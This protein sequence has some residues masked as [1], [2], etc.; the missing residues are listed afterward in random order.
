MVTFIHHSFSC[1]FFRFSYL[2]TCVLTHGSGHLKQVSDRKLRMPS[3]CQVSKC[4]LVYAETMAALLND[5]QFA[6]LPI[7]VSITQCMINRCRFSY[8][9]SSHDTS[10]RM[11]LAHLIKEISSRSLWQVLCEYLHAAVSLAAQV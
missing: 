6:L 5:L 1:F 2:C 4:Q 3:Q 11:F 8:E 9:G 7:H 10:I